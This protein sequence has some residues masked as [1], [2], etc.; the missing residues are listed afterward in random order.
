MIGK[1]RSLLNIYSD[2]NKIL[3]T[4]YESLLP[5][6]FEPPNPQRT[7]VKI[8]LDES[9]KKIV[10]E[11]DSRDLSSHRAAVNTYLYILNSIIKTLNELSQK[12]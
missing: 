1:I 9:N 5:E 6:T 10:F 7:Y 3:L 11:I 2:T 12:T 4:L 8:H